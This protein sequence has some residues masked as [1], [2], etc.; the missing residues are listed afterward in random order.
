MFNMN[1]TGAIKI[2]TTGQVGQIPE[3]RMH[4]MH[5][6]WNAQRLPQEVEGYHVH[7][8]RMQN[9]RLQVAD[10]ELTEELRR[11]E[12]AEHLIQDGQKFD[13]K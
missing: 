13:Q 6:D 11:S 4:L 7:Y 5:D 3:E 1:F 10:Y 8:A 2:E 12:F 9:I